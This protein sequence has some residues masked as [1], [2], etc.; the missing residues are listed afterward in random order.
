MITWGC[1]KS[2]EI[3]SVQ[4]SYS[5]ARVDGKKGD[6]TFRCYDEKGKF[7][8]QS[9]SNSSYGSKAINPTIQKGEKFKL[10]VVAPS[11]STLSCNVSDAKLTNNHPIL[12][13]I[14]KE[15]LT[16]KN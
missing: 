8:V 2:S 10:R 7:G 11:N 9:T 13:P 16:K 4:V 3:Y 15:V 6:F 14:S 12:I 1:N 5:C